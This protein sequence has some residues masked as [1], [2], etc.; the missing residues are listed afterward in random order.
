M[1][2]YFLKEGKNTQKPVYTFKVTVIIYDKVLHHYRN[3]QK[4]QKHPLYYY[5]VKINITCYLETPVPA[6][7]YS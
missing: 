5:N 6:A 1:S 4:N 7:F 3:I 2:N